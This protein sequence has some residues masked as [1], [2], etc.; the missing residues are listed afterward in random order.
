MKERRKEKCPFAALNFNSLFLKTRYNFVTQ[1]SNDY[2]NALLLMTSGWTGT[3]CWGLAAF[4]NAGHRDNPIQ[5][6]GY[7]GVNHWKTPATARGKRSHAD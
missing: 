3:I 7:S 6:R 4:W 1:K 2:S 5:V